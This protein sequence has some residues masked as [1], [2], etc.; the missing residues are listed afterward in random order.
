MQEE[1]K[2]QE[3]TEQVVQEDKKEK[4]ERKLFGKSKVNQEVETLKQQVAEMQNK[5]MYAQAELINYKKRT[6]ERIQDLLKYK[7]EDILLDLTDMIENLDRA[8]SVKVE[9]EESKKIQVGINMVSIQ[10]KE[11]LKKYDVEELETMG[12]PFNSSYMEAMMI[13]NNPEI[14]DEMVTA[15]LRKGYR[16]KDHILRYAQ[17]RVNKNE[18]QE[19]NENQEKEGNE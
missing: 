1:V 14:P 7:N 6:D 12:C 17:V 16:Y 19:E 15:V 3:Q 5:Y 9:S 11:I 10:F 18:I 4:H 8:A 2:E 13:E